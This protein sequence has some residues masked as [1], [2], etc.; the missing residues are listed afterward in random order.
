MIASQQFHSAENQLEN[1]FN[2][3]GENDES[4]EFDAENEEIVNS[5][6]ESQEIIYLEEKIEV[7]EEFMPLEE[8]IS[9]KTSENSDATEKPYQCEV[10]ARTFSHKCSLT[11]HMRIHTG[12]RPYKCNMCDKAFKAGVDYRKNYGRKFR[13]GMF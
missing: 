3:D 10:C 1:G 12:E 8:D 4:I 9:S 13:L 7:K 11:V 6:E 2:H 5:E